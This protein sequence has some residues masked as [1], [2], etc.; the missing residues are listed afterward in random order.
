MYSLLMMKALRFRVKECQRPG[1]HMRSKGAMS[2]RSHVEV[3]MLESIVEDEFKKL[4]YGVWKVTIDVNNLGSSKCTC[5]YFMKNEECKHTLGMKIRQKLVHA[6]P[7]A[8]SVPLGCKG[9]RGRLSTA[10]RAY[11]YSKST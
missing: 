4:N 7:E 6:P 3:V 9:K 10:K 2:V 8:R 11:L 5:P 1:R